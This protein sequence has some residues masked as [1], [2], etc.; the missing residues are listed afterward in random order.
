LINGEKDRKYVSVQ[1]V[2]TLNTCYDVA[3]LTFQLPICHTSQ[4]VL[5]RATNANPQPALFTATNVWRNA[6]LPSER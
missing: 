4:L 3:C 1:K 5:F 2:V 6:T